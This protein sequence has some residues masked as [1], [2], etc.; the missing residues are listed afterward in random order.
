VLF[1]DG[2]ATVE[3]AR[4]DYKSGG[5]GPPVIVVHDGP[6]PLVKKTEGAIK[7]VLGK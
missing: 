3:G 4:L 2:M 5:D 6:G 1:Q 7:T